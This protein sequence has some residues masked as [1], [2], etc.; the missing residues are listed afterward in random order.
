MALLLLLVTGCCSAPSL[1]LWYDYKRREKM[2][3]L[4]Q[5]LASARNHDEVQKVMLLMKRED[6]ISFY[7][8]LL[9]PVSGMATPVTQLEHDLAC[10]MEWGPPPPRVA[11]VVV[12]VAWGY[13]FTCGLFHRIRADEA[14]NCTTE[15]GTRVF[16]FE[17]LIR[18]ALAIDREQAQEEIGRYV[19]STRM[20]PF[21]NVCVMES[22]IQGN[23]ISDC[24]L[25]EWL[26]KCAFSQDLP[27]RVRSK[28]GELL[29]QAKMDTIGW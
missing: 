9:P 14:V 4:A 27:A 25:L 8:S 19:T 13:M 18:H 17:V 24:R 7:T 1:P 16:T 6:W 3:P 20:T 10:L 23:D 15:V 28:A 21:M 29:K 22:L 26:Q 11:R 5:R 2:T 12:G